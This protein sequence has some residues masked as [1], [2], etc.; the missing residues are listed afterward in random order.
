MVLQRDVAAMVWGFATAGSK[1][2]TT[3]AGKTLT[4]ITPMSTIAWHLARG[5]HGLPPCHRHQE[6]ERSTYGRTDARASGAQ[7][8]IKD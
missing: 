7:D 2:T 1:T 6:C 4:A 8:N 3:F 5:V